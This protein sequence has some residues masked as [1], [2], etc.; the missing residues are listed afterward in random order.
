MRSIGLA[1][2]VSA[3]GLVGCGGQ[4]EVPRPHGALLRRPTSPKGSARGG[5]VRGLIARLWPLNDPVI[6]WDGSVHELIARMGTS[7]LA[8]VVESWAERWRSASSDWYFA[9][10][11]LPRGASLHSARRVRST[12][13]FF[14]P[15]RG[16]TR[17]P[18]SA[19][20]CLTLLD[21]LDGDDSI[22]VFIE[23]LLG[24]P[25]PRVRRHALHALSCDLC[26]EAPVCVDVVPAIAECVRTDNNAKVKQ[27]AR[28]VLFRHLPDERAKEALAAH[29]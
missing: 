17:P 6:R 22:P 1:V 2:V 23:A 26:K 12:S 8:T 20:K 16:L 28:Q 4:T 13:R 21:H 29:P 18:R 27:Q 5:S 9:T 7:L 14:A 25:V 19:G 15:V 11:P 24:D 3:V 10:S